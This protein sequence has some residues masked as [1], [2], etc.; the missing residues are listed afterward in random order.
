MTTT[1]PAVL[2]REIHRLRRFAQN[3]HEQLDRFPRQLKVQQAKAARQEEIHKEA[4]D[5]LKKLKVVN[6][7]KEVT[8]KATHARVKKYEESLNTAADKKE[9]DAL[10]HQIATCRA[11]AQTLEDEI[12]AGLSE[13]EERTA[14]L[15]VLA[16]A[17][18]KAKQD[19]VQWEKD[20]RQRHARQAE[21][22]KETQEKTTEAESAV[23]PNQ[24]TQYNRMVHAMGADALSAVQGHNC[25]ACMT[26]V[27]AQTYN[28]LLQQHFVFCKACGRILYLPEMAAAE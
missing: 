1:A 8:L 26:E 21:E 11:Q 4:Q 18:E 2:M 22:L 15:P 23:P 20:A 16:K 3:L 5:A 24:R 6:N 9:Y 12:L 10:K 13:I 27:T 25:V 14:Q 7:D 17:V 19:L 28:E